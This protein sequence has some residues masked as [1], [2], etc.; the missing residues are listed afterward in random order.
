MNNTVRGMTRRKL[1]QLS[2][3]NTIVNPLRCSGD[4]KGLLA[5]YLSGKPNR[6]VKIWDVKKYSSMMGFELPELP[7]EAFQIIIPEVVS[8]A[9]GPIVPY[10]EEPYSPW[11]IGENRAHFSLQIPKTVRMEAMV[12]F[13]DQEIEARVRV[14]NL[15]QRTWDGVSAFTCFAYFDAPGFDDPQ[16]KRTYLPVDGRWKSISELYAEHSPGDSPTAAFSVAGSPSLKDLGVEQGHPQVL[17]KGCACVI[18]TDGNWVAGI[19]AER[20]AYV[21]NNGGYRWRC[22]HANPLIGT[23]VPG[24]TA[25]GANMIYIFRGTIADF[26]KRCEASRDA[27]GLKAKSLQFLNHGSSNP[28]QSR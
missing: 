6:K 22:I 23:V 25:E 17:S 19:T 26:M 12:L 11:E 24:A 10:T 15:S 14:T 20:V 4:S 18:S 3:V 8:E 1:L 27:A 13:R 28:G 9:K 7:G 21:F 2:A 16:L 5:T